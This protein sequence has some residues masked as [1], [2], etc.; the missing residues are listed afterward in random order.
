[1]R[2]GGVV[3]SATAG[4][5]SVAAPMVVTL[6]SSTGIPCKSASCWRRASRSAA[7]RPITRCAVF[8][9]CI[10]MLRW[11]LSAPS[12]GFSSALATTSAAICC[13]R[14]ARS[15]VLKARRSSVLGSTRRSGAVSVAAEPTAVSSAA[16][17]W[18]SPL[19]VAAR[20]AV[21]GARGRCGA[22]WVAGVA[23]PDSATGATTVAV[24]AAAASCGAGWA[25]SEATPATASRRRARRSRRKSEMAA[26]PSLAVSATAGRSSAEGSASGARPVSFVLWSISLRSF[27]KCPPRALNSK[28]S[29]VVRTPQGE[30]WEPLLVA[31]SKV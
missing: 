28:D 13:L 5:S 15:E 19:I 21:R 29:R 23:S 26:R 27:P 24:F 1:M 18:A 2:E 16:G 11:R 30:L 12:A 17:C 20:R 14:R 22:E 7:T 9:C 31:A 10:I 4:R 8:N 25:L 3:A 6:I